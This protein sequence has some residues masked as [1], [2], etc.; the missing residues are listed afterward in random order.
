MELSAK[1]IYGF[2]PLTIFAK[3]SIL[4]IRIGSEYASEQQQQAAQITFI[5]SKLA[6]EALEK[7][8]KYIQ[9]KIKAPERRQWR[10]SGVF[11]V[12][13]EH[14]SHLFLVIILL[15]LNK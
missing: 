4:V 7:G 10:R 15:T 8:V 12:N 2:Q 3:C 13:F 5:C 6:I 14:I 1:I 11:I 9:S